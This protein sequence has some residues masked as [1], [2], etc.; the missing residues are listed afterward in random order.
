MNAEGAAPNNREKKVQGRA[1]RRR[2]VQGT[3][4]L[5]HAITNRLAKEAQSRSG[6][7]SRSPKP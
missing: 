3:R 7:R 6:K 4:A 1:K 2:Y 5:T